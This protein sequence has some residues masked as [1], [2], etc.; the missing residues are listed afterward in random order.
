MSAYK[1]NGI[2]YRLLSLLKQLEGKPRKRWLLRSDGQ[3]QAN[4]NVQVVYVFVPADAESTT[5]NPNQ[6]LDL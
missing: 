5:A 6:Q 4:L 1:L 3:A 2:C